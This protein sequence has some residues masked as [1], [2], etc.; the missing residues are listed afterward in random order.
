MKPLEEAVLAEID[1]AIKKVEWAGHKLQLEPEN[2][3]RQFQEHCAY[4]AQDQY[5]GISSYGGRL[6]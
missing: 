5:R 6:V 3:Y 1:K 2:L 4:N